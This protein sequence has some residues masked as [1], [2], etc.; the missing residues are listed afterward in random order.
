MGF[1]Y[2][3]H[4][5]KSKKFRPE[6]TEA[7]IEYCLF[8]SNK[9]KDKKWLDVYNAISKVPPSGRLLKVVYKIK[10]KSIKIITAYWL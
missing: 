3:G 2:S 7:V 4:Y 5:I 6:I 10:G 9:I 8:N 1:E